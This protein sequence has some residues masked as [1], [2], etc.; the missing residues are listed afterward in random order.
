MRGAASESSA[1]PVP[2]YA[3]DPVELNDACRTK[4]KLPN[5]TDSDATLLPNLIHQLGSARV[6]WWLD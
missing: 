4:L 5:Q 3:A 6:E 1:A 2:H